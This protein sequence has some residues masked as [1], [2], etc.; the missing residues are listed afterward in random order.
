MSEFSKEIKD[1]VG[2]L[3]VGYSKADLE[4]KMELLCRVTQYLLEKGHEELWVS[5]CA[6]P[7]DPILNVVS[8]GWDGAD[9]ERETLADAERIGAESVVVANDAWFVPTLLV[10]H[11]CEDLSVHPARREAIMVEAKDRVKHLGGHK[12]F[13]RTC[14]GLIFGDLTIEPIADSWLEYPRK[15]G[16]RN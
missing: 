2:A 9:I 13:V 4:E 12:P 8:C 5:I 6:A 10:D 3:L 11:P 15:A 7:D 16:A 1:E 14:D